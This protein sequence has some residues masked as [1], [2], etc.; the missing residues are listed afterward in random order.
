MN[1]KK[2]KKEITKWKRLHFSNQIAKEQGFCSFICM[3]ELEGKEKAL[4]MLQNKG[5][6][7]NRG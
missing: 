4:Q 2:C 1:C 3:A 5:N 7:R 6:T